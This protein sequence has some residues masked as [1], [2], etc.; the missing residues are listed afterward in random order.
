LQSCQASRTASRTKTLVS[1][2]L[3]DRISLKPNAASCFS[4]QATVVFQRK[5]FFRAGSVLDASEPGSLPRSPSGFN[6]HGVEQLAQNDEEILLDEIDQEDLQGGA[7]CC[8]VR[9]QSRV[10]RISP[11]QQI[12]KFWNTSQFSVTSADPTLLDL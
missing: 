6:P 10:S 8:I 7:R 9:S 11:G 5:A 12:Q 2:L 4:P 1:S 3:P